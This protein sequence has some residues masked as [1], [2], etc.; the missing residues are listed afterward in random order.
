MG[1][2]ELN[3]PQ[4]GNAITVYY[5]M[6]KQAKPASAN[7]YWLNY[8]ENDKYFIAK[9]LIDAWWGNNAPAWMRYAGRHLTIPVMPDGPLS[10]DFCTRDRKL[11]P[12]IFSHGLTAHR[13]CY[14]INA[15]EFASHGYIVFCMDHLD[16]SNS[17]TERK[18]YDYY[19]AVEFD[20]SFPWYNAEN[21]N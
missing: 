5:P 6:D 12:V 16:G 3:L 19:E 18:V 7:K 14:A 21:M 10:E 4:E 15:M 11:L 9:T 2:S 13:G 1:T 8:R 20:T 17:Y